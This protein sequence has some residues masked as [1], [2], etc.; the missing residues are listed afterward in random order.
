MKKGLAL[1]LA[2]VMVF[3]LACPAA[4]AEKDDTITIKIATSMAQTHPVVVTLEEVK[5][6]LS[7]QSDGR[8]VL[9]IYPAG[10]LGSNLPLQRLRDGLR[11]L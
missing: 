1:L 7:E 4:F 11:G 6:Y 8:I 5:E 2:L 10:A 9:E 3:A